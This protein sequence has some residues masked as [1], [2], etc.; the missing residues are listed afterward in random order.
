M[1]IFS[2]ILLILLTHSFIILM[3]FLFWRGNIMIKVIEKKIFILL[4]IACFIVI[5]SGLAKAGGMSKSG[6]MSTTSYS[7][8]YTTSS[9]KMGGM[10]GSSTNYTSYYNT[11]DFARTNALL[12]YTGY[13]PYSYNWG[14]GTTPYGYNYANAYSGLSPYS[15]GGAFNNYGWGGTTSVVTGEN[16]TTEQSYTTYVPGG[17]VTTTVGKETETTV[18]PV[19]NLFGNTYGYGYSNP[20]G[21]G[22]TYYG[23]LYGNTYLNNPLYGY[24]YGSSY[25]NPYYLW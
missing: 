5:F 19:Q 23:N 18:V 22:N 20:L 7:P 15:L 6:G 21:L 14:V 1:K 17:E 16:Y 9:S 8:Y 3:Y 4:L 25:S 13:N 12:G 24:G 2:L 10:H 11:A